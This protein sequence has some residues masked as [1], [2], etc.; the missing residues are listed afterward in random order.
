MVCATMS[1]K[2][3]F[4]SIFLSDIV[5]HLSAFVR[6]ITKVYGFYPVRQC[7]TKISIC[8][9]F[10]RHV[11]DIV[12]Q[13]CVKPLFYMSSL[14]LKFVRHCPT[15]ENAIFKVSINKLK[16][17]KYMYFCTKPHSKNHCVMCAGKEVAC[18]GECNIKLSI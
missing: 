8:E 11:P 6:Q 12:R 17:F 7:P 2:S 1:D 18:L 15:K 9:T 10:V 13:M 3:L 16:P 4:F 14:R 5:R